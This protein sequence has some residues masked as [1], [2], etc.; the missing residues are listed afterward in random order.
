M[1]NSSKGNL[2]FQDQKNHKRL[3]N[4]MIMVKILKNRHS[5]VVNSKM[6]F[7]MKDGLKSISTTLNLMDFKSKLTLNH[8]IKSSTNL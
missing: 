7:R 3:L 1:E 6:N 8:Q 5:M 2:N 4:N